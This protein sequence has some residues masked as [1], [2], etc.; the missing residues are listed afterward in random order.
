MQD[1]SQDGLGFGDSLQVVNPEITI[2]DL[3]VS[4][5]SNK[6]NRE[7]KE[8]CQGYQYGS[9]RPAMRKCQNRYT[10]INFTIEPDQ[11]SDEQLLALVAENNQL[12]S[13]IES[14]LE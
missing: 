13:T 11:H 7:Y 3:L 4:L 5:D 2:Q 6:G 10:E 12:E 8:V 1:S 14:I 9:G